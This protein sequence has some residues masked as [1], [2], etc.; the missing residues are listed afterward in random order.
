LS[1]NTHRPAIAAAF[2]GNFVVGCGV[3]VVPG[4][5]DLLARDL[6]IAV[7]SAG[8][9]LSLAAWTMC[10]GA[11]LLAAV[12]SRV[13]RRLLLVLSLLL[14]AGGHVA[15]ALAP[16]FLT[17]LWLRPIAVLGAAVFTPQVAATLALMVPPEQ[18]STAVT[19]AFVGWSLASVLGMPIGNLL[20]DTL[21]WRASFAAVAVLGLLSAVIV[22][23][24]IPSGLRVTPLSLQSWAHVLGTARLRW[25]L[26]ATMGWCMGHFTVIGYITAALREGLHASPALQAGL[27]ALMGA[28]GLVGNI[29]LSRWVARMGADRCA[30]I[31][32]SFVFWGMLLWIVALSWLQAL[33]IMSTAIVIWGLGN[34]AFNSAQQARL[35]YSAPELASAS[36]ALNSSSLYAGQ[37]MGAMLGASLV[38]S[39]GYDALGPSALLVVGAALLCSWYA[40]KVQNLHR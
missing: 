37:A 19:S 30:R 16:D 9:L 35:A 1:H 31:A 2:L 4:M 21:S 20:A 33:W 3:L 5:L 27:M 17:L 25:I 18:R 7:P 10:L 11:P 36:I 29:T 39:V 34:F 28:C 40:D 26:L 24:V 38:G 23:R 22:W 32:L 6:D 14:L 8:S 12:T 13:D 15:C